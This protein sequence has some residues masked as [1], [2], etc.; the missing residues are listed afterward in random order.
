MEAEGWEQKARAYEKRRLTDQAL[1]CLK[2]S[3]EASQ[4]P[5]PYESLH[6][7]LQEISHRAAFR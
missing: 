6:R 7:Y 4:R 3:L 1:E 5:A 2:S